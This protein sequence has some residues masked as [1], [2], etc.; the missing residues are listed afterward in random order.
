MSRQYKMYSYNGREYTR[1]EVC[2]MLGISDATF[3]K[4]SSQ[5]L[6]IE[7]MFNI[8]LNKDKKPYSYNG[9]EYTREELCTI[10]DISESHFYK[11]LRDGLTPDQIVNRPRHY[12]Y[13]GMSNTKLYNVYQAMLHRCYD[14][15]HTYYTDYHNRGINICDEWRND[16]TK[17]FE[18]AMN[19]GYREGLTIDRIDNNKGYY[20]SNCRWT[21]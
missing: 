4:W 2:T 16:K 6:S 14:P 3:Y 20:P 7:Q 15:K 1:K 11:L 21:T 9:K 12:T 10:A 19:N 5:G 13:H 18:W 17:F 8:K